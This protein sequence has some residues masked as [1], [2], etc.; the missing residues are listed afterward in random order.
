MLTLPRE[1]QECRI[2]PFAHRDLRNG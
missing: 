1:F 2:S